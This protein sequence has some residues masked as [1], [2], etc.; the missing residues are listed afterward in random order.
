MCMC[1]FVRVCTCFCTHRCTCKY[2][3]IQCCHVKVWT[4]PKQPKGQLNQTRSLACAVL[5]IIQTHLPRRSP[6]HMALVWGLLV[7]SSRSWEGRPSF[8][9]QLNGL[10]PHR[11]VAM[12]S[13]KIQ[14]SRIPVH[15]RKWICTAHAFVRIFFQHSQAHKLCTN[16]HMHTN[17]YSTNMCIYIYINMN[18]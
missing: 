11:H 13:W 12:L 15:I 18:T 10:L 2:S 14:S 9:K 4:M 17:A 5:G 16:T 8:L 6:G 3:S 1:V 7:H